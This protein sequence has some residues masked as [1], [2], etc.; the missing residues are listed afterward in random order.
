M[1]REKSFMA[2]LFPCIESFLRVFCKGKHMIVKV[3]KRKAGS[4]RDLA[5]EEYEIVQVNTL[6]ELLIEVVSM[7][8]KKSIRRPLKVKIHFRC[9]WHYIVWDCMMWMRQL[10]GRYSY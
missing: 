10:N 7:M 3:K 6:E 9:I 4:Y 5:F 8:R 1:E 2:S